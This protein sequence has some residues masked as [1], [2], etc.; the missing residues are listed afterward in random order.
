MRYKIGSIVRSVYHSEC[1]IVSYDDFC[2]YNCKEKGDDYLYTYI[3]D[4]LTLIKAPRNKRK[5]KPASL[6]Y[7]MAKKDEWE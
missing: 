4:D 7:R 2:A 5:T 1:M 6:A 3:E